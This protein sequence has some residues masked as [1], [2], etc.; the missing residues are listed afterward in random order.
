MGVLRCCLKVSLLVLL[1][2]EMSSYC[3]VFVLFHL[4]SPP[5]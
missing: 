3:L 5:L 1:D 2:E 4:V